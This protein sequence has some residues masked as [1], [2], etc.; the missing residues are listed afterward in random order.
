[1]TECNGCGGCCDPVVL[2]FTQQQV[3]FA[4]KFDIDDE[5]RRFVLEDLTPMRP[6]LALE[7]RPEMRG[8]PLVDAA[9]DLML[10]PHFYTC[11]HFDEETR[12][13]TNYEGRPPVCRGY[14]W[15][16]SGPKHGAALPP[17]CSFNADIG[18]PVKFT[19][20]AAHVRRK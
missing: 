8:R 3:K 14:P 10:L 11:K 4:S 15:Y 20:V 2:P 17:A 7:K 6:K 19:G 9:G 12:A 18:Q 5:D 16:D 1:M 13:C